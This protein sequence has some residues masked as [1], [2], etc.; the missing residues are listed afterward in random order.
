MV[1][2]PNNDAGAEREV[3]EMLLYIV[4]ALVDHPDEAGIILLS[5]PGDFIFCVHVHPDDVGRLIGNYGQSVSPL[6]C[7]VGITRR[8]LDQ[9]F[10]R[11]IV[12]EASRLQRYARSTRKSVDQSQE[13]LAVSSPVRFSVPKPTSCLS[14][15]LRARY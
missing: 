6:R 2:T 15:T 9:R 5:R 8:K 12:Q 1:T 7:I 11:D 10:N 3:R 14:A 13:L 4:R